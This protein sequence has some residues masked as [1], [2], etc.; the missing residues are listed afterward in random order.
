MAWQVRARR[1]KRA[2]STDRGDQGAG[3]QIQREG[4]D[5]VAGALQRGS[6]KN[7]YCMSIGA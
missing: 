7:R 2:T 1:G 5:A 6:G 3:Q 4:Q